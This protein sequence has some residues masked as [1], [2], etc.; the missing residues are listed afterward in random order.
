MDTRSK[1]SEAQYFLDN[2]PNVQ[3]NPEEFYYNLSAFLTAWRSALDVM[4]YDLAEH[5]NLGFT[6]EDEMTARDFTLA[7]KILGNT[8][9]TQFISWW[10]QK[11]GLL[12]ATPLWRKRNINFHRGR[13]GVSQYTIHASGSGGTSNTIAFSSSSDTVVTTNMVDPA[14][15]L[16]TLVPGP[17]PIDITVYTPPQTTTTQTNVEYYFDD[18]PN[19]T[20]IETCR[21]AYEKMVEIV[22]EAETQYTV[23]L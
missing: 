9:A 3:N 21:T 10:R 11:Q 4:L 2:L 6:R 19:Q 5:F 14:D 18:L 8:V 20:V 23:R 1:L 17:G 13:L 7:A 22:E 15:F 12:R 16:E